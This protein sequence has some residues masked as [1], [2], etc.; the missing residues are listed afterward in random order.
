MKKKSLFFL[1]LL[2]FQILCPP[3]NTKTWAEAG[4][5]DSSLSFYI[6]PKESYVGDEV[7]LYYEFFPP[8]DFA[9][10][11]QTN[12]I[13]LEKP[14][15]SLFASYD[16]ELQSIE[17]VQTHKKGL[18]KSYALSIY[19]IPFVT[20]VIEIPEF[21]LRELLAHETQKTKEDFGASLIPIKI[22]PFE[23]QNILSIYP[24]SSL[25]PMRGIILLPGT[26]VF[27]YLLLAILI[28]ISIFLFYIGYAA[29]KIRFSFFGLWKRLFYFFYVF[30]IK[31]KIKKLLKKNI[32]LGEF[33][34]IVHRYLCLYL[35]KRF[36]IDFSAA[37]NTEILQTIRMSQEGLLSEKEETIL[38]DIQTLF[39]RL[40]F[41]RFS[42][43]G[44]ENKGE[45]E[46]EK[47]ERV[48]QLL[49]LIAEMESQHV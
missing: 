44:P 38:F 42:L 28:G 49:G 31:R 7:Q 37:T 35:T 18:E 2:S 36:G 45:E 27:V 20:G 29:K 1:F 3:K 24:D 47:K 6:S 30:G 23:I 22:P 34:Q 11:F 40:D 12:K 46:R 48:S 32:R 5:N 4:F 26:S 43:E 41:L 9:S 25:R 16:C 15:F 39:I 19:F 21:D 14:Q 17:I 10:F 33:S 8:A 13:F